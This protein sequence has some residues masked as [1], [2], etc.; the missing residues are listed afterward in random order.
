MPLLGAHMS[1]AGGYYKALEAAQALGMT[2]CQ[3]FT[4][5]NNQWAGKPLTDE[6]CRL[7]QSTWAQSGLQK[8][9]A[10]NSYLINLASPDD[11]LWQRS[12][13]AMTIESERAEALGLT[14]VV[15]HPGSYVTSSAEAGLQRIIQGLDEVLKQTAGFRVRLWLETT[16][17]QG[18]NLGWRFEELATLLAGVCEHQRLGVCLDT[19]HV[20]AAGYGMQ[21]A[22]D[23]AATMQEFDDVIGLARLEAFHLNDSLKP[24]SSR[25]DRHA[26]IGEGTLG[27]EAFRLLLNDPRF[28]EHPMYLETDKGDRN[29]EEL[30]AINLRTLRSLIGRTTPCPPPATASEPLKA[31]PKKKAA[32]SKP[33]AQKAAKK[34]SAVVKKAVAKKAAAKKRR[35][36]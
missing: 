30:D 12:I 2:T 22:A 16:A 6:D 26:H 29:G 32:A 36:E 34:K 14:G 7:F 8:V 25:V 17:G 27:L 24:R 4:K 3:I 31:T 10:H 11:A 19:C 35:S 21:T 5:N 20:W 1:I 18:S 23:Y 28:A 9:C 33:A 15:L 13:D